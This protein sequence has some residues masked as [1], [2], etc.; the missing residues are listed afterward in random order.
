MN[1]SNKKCAAASQIACGAHKK[2]METTTKVQLT[3]TVPPLAPEGE[4]D[5]PARGQALVGPAEAAAQAPVAAG[6]GREYTRTGSGQP[7]L[8]LRVKLSSPE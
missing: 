6:P 3:T 1:L 7:P 2:S 8:L 4:R 5:G